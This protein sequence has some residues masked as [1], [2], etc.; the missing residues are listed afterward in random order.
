MQYREPV[1][2]FDTSLM[3]WVWTRG[4]PCVIY[5]MHRP[6]PRLKTIMAL[7][8]RRVSVLNDA[9]HLLTESSL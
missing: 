4:E 7:M 6:V 3:R 5:T 8:T 2:D 9:G 1:E